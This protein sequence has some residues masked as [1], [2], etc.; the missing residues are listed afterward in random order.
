MRLP[1]SNNDPHKEGEQAGEQGSREAKQ[2]QC[3]LCQ[4]QRQ[5]T[6][7]GNRFGKHTGSKGKQAKNKSQRITQMIEAG[8]F[9]FCGKH[10]EVFIYIPQQG[11]LSGSKGKWIGTQARLIRGV[12]YKPTHANVLQI[13][14][15]RTLTMY[16]ML[17]RSLTLFY[18]ATSYSIFQT[19]M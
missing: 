15:E 18:L 7:K 14:K 1:K 11:K 17:P 2:K 8:L 4:F 16:L 5:S 3:R 19:L 9:N 6:T 10:A 12:S 13:L